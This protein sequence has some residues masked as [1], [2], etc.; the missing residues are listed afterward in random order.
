[1]ANPTFTDTVEQKL[2]IEPLGGPQSPLAFTDRFPDSIYNKAP[3]S[4]LIRLLTA[5]VG[6]AGAGW[7]KQQTFNAR[8]ILEQEGLELFDLDRFYGNPLAFGR[9]ADE[10]YENDPRGTLSREEWNLVRI[11]DERYRAR[12]L[13]FFNGARAGT[14]P[15]GMRLVAR[16]G[17]GHEVEIIE[18]YQHLF[19]QHSDDPLG[20][21]YQGHTRSIQEMVVIPRRETSRSEV[22]T[23]TITGEP[24]SGT[25]VLEFQGQMTAPLAIDASYWTIQ[26]ALEA[27]TSIGTGNVVVRGA[28]PWTV[29][30]QG[31]LSKRDVPAL[32][33]YPTLTGG[34]SPNVIVETT[35][36]G[37]QSSD[38]I[39][40]IPPTDQ[41]H[42][43]TALDRI[44]PVT[45]IATT[46]VGEGLRKRQEWTSA[47]AS[48]EYNEV[49]RY[50][51]GNTAIHWPL[52]DQTNWIEAAKEKESRRSANDLQ[53]H[54]I[55]F[56]SPQQVY[57]YTDQALSNSSYAT[58][59]DSTVA[60]SSTHVGQFSIEQRRL[61]SLTYL[62]ENADNQLEYTADR[63]M[64]D[65]YEPLSVST[66][67]TQNPPVQLINGIY[68]TSYTTL[69][70]VPRIRYKE[71]QFWASR[72]RTQ[73]T[74]YIELDLGSAQAVNFLT[75]EVSRK[76]L[77]IRIEIDTLDQ[78]PRRNF[79]PVIRSNDYFTESILYSPQDPNPW[80]IAEFNFEDA[81]A[82]IPFTRYIRIAFTRQ[83]FSDVEAGPWSIEARNLRVGRNVSSY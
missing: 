58:N 9:I 40:S 74:E 33:V 11:A 45:V 67:T 28:G 79:V 70:G 71:E 56:H 19:D 78:G 2:L 35:Q 50:V 37:I 39:V 83:T 65:Y 3:E 73:G 77:M 34:T 7:L 63:I 51:T 54:Y 15:L 24:D 57:A 32:V 43:Q 64:A 21:P 38:E 62:R 60:Y 81:A 16:S 36:S 8:L 6:P 31:D 68:P 80:T 55:G 4:H 27:L 52:P 47:I 22:Q 25:F 75:F 76:P 72:E 29:A 13:D 44:K 10:I 69:P 66:Q 59:V 30:F 20:I 5:M 48:S 18:N 82:R 41:H 23:I 49:I 26:E 14:T 46:G 61:A 53:Y 17:L 12:A 42:L 1:M